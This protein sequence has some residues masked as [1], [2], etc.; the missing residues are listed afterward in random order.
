[1]SR[2][3]GICLGVIVVTP[4]AASAAASAF[5]LAVG[6][7]LPTLAAMTFACLVNTV[8]GLMSRVPPRYELAAHDGAVAYA[9]FGTAFY[10]ALT[11][12]IAERL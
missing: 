3:N 4:L 7:L 12:A 6:N 10:T 11:V 9:V 1:M 5:S 8:A 2:R